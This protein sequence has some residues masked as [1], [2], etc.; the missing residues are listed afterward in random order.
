MERVDLWAHGAAFRLH[1]PRRRFDTENYNHMHNSPAEIKKRFTLLLVAFA[2][3]TSRDADKQKGKRARTLLRIA[4]LVPRKAALFVSND[5]H[6]PSGNGKANTG[7]RGR[8]VTLNLERLSAHTFISFDIVFTL[9][10][11]LYLSTYKIRCR[12]LCHILK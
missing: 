9:T 10:K 6:A 12:Q 1:L 4:D 5:L 3:K 11:Q 7:I 2:A 8:L